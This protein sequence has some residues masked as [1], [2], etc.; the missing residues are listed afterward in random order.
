[1]SRPLLLRLICYFACLTSPKYVRRRAREYREQFHW[2]SCVPVLFLFAQ[3]FGINWSTED[4]IYKN[5][6]KLFFSFSCRALRL[7]KENCFFF[8]FTFH[9]HKTALSSTLSMNYILS[10]HRIEPV[11]SLFARQKSFHNLSARLLEF[12][13]DSRPMNLTVAR[14][15]QLEQLS[16]IVGKML[17]VASDKLIVHHIVATLNHVI[18]YSIRILSPTEKSEQKSIAKSPSITGDR[19]SPEEY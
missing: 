9:S 15:E 10:R 5:F 4:G 18:T 1:M 3:M 16:V 2:L 7:V 13:W 12:I 14:D 19:H 8:Q 17:F 11:C 6:L